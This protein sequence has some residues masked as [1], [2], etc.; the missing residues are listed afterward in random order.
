MKIV[1]PNGREMDE[2]PAKFKEIEPV[3]AKSDFIGWGYPGVK[4][5]CLDYAKL[6]MK[7]AG[8]YVGGGQDPT[9][10]YPY[11]EKSGPNESCFKKAVDYIQ[12]SLENRIPVLVGVDDHPGS[13]NSDNT[14]DHFIVI[15]GMGYDENKGNYF[16]AYDNATG[17]QKKGTS[18]KNRLYVDYE[19]K[20]I[21]CQ[22]PFP[23]NYA[24]DPR[25]RPYTV[26]QVRESKKRK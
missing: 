16:T 24:T 12:S 19:N 17:D 21:Q 26:T 8:Y 22:E 1:D 3:I 10:I 11:N 6:Q 5:N 14:T 15:V 18:D 23:N 25:L 4:N 9:N 2:P 13:P 20:K 7:K